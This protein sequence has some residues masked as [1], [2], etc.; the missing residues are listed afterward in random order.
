MR[1][2]IKWVGGKSRLLGQVLAALPARYGTYYEPFV[3]GGA[4]WLQLAPAQAVIGDSCASL[5]DMYSEARYNPGNL[6]VKT[7]KLIDSHSTEQYYAVRKIYNGFG[8]DADRSALF[9]YLNRA[10]FNGLYRVN[11]AGEFNVPCGKHQPTLD[12]Q[13]IYDAMALLRRTSIKCGDYQ[14]TTEGATKG[15][16]VYLDPPYDQTFNG[17]SKDRFDQDELVAHARKL[18]KRGCHVVMSN[19]DTPM[20]RQRYVDWDIREVSRPNKWT[21][22]GGKIGELLIVGT[23]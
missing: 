3:G 14:I 23:P 17:Y 8:F 6:I 20:N 15:D 13:K 22:T 19:S 16:L 5:I 7:Q 1:P 9:L 10:C 18:R 12:A 21:K 2:W 11:K 4:V